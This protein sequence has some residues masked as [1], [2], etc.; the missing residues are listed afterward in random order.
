MA[1]NCFVEY[2]GFSFLAVQGWIVERYDEMI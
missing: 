1:L 2:F